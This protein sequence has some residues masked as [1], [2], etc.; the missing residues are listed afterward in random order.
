MIR[1]GINAMPSKSTL[2]SFLEDPEVRQLLG[3]QVTRELI[4]FLCMALR[5]GNQ[6]DEVVMSSPKKTDVK[7][8][9]KQDSED[10]A[11]D[12]LFTLEIED[13]DDLDALWH[14]ASLQSRKS[15]LKDQEENEAHILQRLKES[16]PK[17]KAD[18]LFE[19]V[20][21]PVVRTP[22]ERGSSGSCKLPAM[23]LRTF[24]KLTCCKRKI[25]SISLLSKHTAEASTSGLRRLGS[26]NSWG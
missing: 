9:E 17:L 12:E 5:L 15:Q 23:M 11:D 19:I 7:S 8:M 6:S 13:L 18:Q 1:L 14:M 2:L 10:Q 16:A 26:R 24:E 25:A 22:A 3:P 20:K 4:N 21:Y